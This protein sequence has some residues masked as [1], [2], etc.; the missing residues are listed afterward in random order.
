MWQQVTQRLAIYHA[1]ILG[2]PIPAT[3]HK[4]TSC[5]KLWFI[6]A[7]LLWLD[8]WCSRS[9]IWGLLLFSCPYRVWT[10][11]LYTSAFQ[12]YQIHIRLSNAWPVLQQGPSVV[13]SLRYV[14]QRRN[15]WENTRVERT[16][17]KID[18]HTSKTLRLTYQEL[19]KVSAKIEV[20]RRLKRLVPTN[21][22]LILYKTSAKDS[23]N[24]VF[25]GS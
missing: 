13:A 2:V 3:V 14:V 25:T 16:C 12:L 9:C 10:G 5:N 18:D 20:L 24:L 8:K 17:F 6:P 22:A 19:K 7:L 1:M 15:T 23:D 21:V 4:P 11:V